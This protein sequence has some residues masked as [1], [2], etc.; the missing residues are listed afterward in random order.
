MFCVTICRCVREAGRIRVRPEEL[1]AALD[2]LG[3]TQ[4]EAAEALGVSLRTVQSWVAGKHEIPG[5]AA[6][7]VRLWVQREDLRPSTPDGM[8]GEEALRL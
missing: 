1:Q 8:R 3:I 5:P 6:R 7:L 2:E 4:R